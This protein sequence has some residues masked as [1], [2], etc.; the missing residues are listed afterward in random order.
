MDEEVTLSS[1]IIGVLLSAAKTKKYNVSQLLFEMLLASEKW[2]VCVEKLGWVTEEKIVE[3]KKE[4]KEKANEHVKE[5]L[6]VLKDIKSQ[7]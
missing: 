3:L 2:L 7:K 5:T 6:T 4:A 1:V